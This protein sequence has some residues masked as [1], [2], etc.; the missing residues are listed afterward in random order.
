ML[1]RG[2]KNEKLVHIVELLTKGISLPERTKPHM[3][4]GASTVEL[5]SVIYRQTGFFSMR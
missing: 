3:L 1:K 5:W 2:C 4:V